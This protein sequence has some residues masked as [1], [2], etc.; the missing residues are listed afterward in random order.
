MALVQNQ[1]LYQYCYSM[2]SDPILKL[3]YQKRLEQLGMDVLR[4]TKRKSLRSE[5]EN[6]RTL[7]A[8]ETKASEP[9]LE[10]LPSILTY[11]DKLAV[12]RR[13]LH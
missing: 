6:I 11:K 4:S 9:F 10:S 1:Q 3:E 13:I 2:A 5:L 8:A 7:D 12:M